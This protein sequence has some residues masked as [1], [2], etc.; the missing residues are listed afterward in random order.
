LPAKK[1]SVRAARSR[2]GG[3]EDRP[4]C[5]L[6]QRGMGRSDHLDQAL[7]GKTPAPLAGRP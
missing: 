1:A 3:N 6:V 7:L 2:R 5:G 4:V